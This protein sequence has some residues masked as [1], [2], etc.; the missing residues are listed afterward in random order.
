MSKLLS[1]YML[2]TNLI[3]DLSAAVIKCHKSVI[4]C[5]YCLSTASKQGFLMCVTIVAQ[6]HRRQPLGLSATQFLHL[7][8]LHC[9]HI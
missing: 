5:L 8:A 3:S 9:V 6:P 2:G 7:H 4:C 1:R